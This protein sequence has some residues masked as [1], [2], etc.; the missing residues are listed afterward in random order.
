MIAVSQAVRKT[1]AA[2]LSPSLNNRVTVILN[3]IDL[4]SFS[5]VGHDR[6]EIEKDCHWKT[7]T[8]Q[9]GLSAS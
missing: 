2:V 8:L 7:T 1:L 6:E 4:K 9:S 3:A 5:T